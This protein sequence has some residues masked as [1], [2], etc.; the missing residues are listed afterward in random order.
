[1]ADHGPKAFP[2]PARFRDNKGVFVQQDSGD[3]GMTLRDW[4]A[5][6]KSAGDKNISAEGCYTWADHMMQERNQ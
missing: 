1:M 2:S 3:P 4:F 6:M 5:G